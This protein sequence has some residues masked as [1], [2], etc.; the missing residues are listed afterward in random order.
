MLCKEQAAQ[1]EH[2]RKTYGERATN[3]GMQVLVEDG[4]SPLAIMEN[5]VNDS[6]SPL[7]AMELS[8]DD[9]D[10]FSAAQH[11]DVLLTDD[12]LLGACH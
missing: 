5:S 4:S 2:Y 8:L 9:E 6:D 10:S 3:K 1:L 11:E 12:I 7:A